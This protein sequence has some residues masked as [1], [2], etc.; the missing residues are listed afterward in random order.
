MV[1]RKEQAASAWSYRFWLL[2]SCV[3]KRLKQGECFFRTAELKNKSAVQ[4]SAWS[5]TF[6]SEHFETERRLTSQQLHTWTWK[7]TATLLL[8]LHGQRQWWRPMELFL[9]YSLTIIKL[10]FLILTFSSLFATKMPPRTKAAL[11]VQ[12]FSRQH[13]TVRRWW[14]QSEVVSEWEVWIAHCLWCHKNLCVFCVCVCDR[15]K[16]PS[17]RSCVASVCTTWRR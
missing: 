4:S 15:V 9:N 8:A 5:R 17:Q 11:N 6:F 10:I 3:E 16:E 2:A 14:E 12:F 13:R 1:S 7:T